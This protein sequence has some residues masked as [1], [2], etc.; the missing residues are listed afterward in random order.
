M[1]R[2]KTAIMAVAIVILILLGFLSGCDFARERI[3]PTI[4]R[5][6]AP[7]TVQIYFYDTPQQV[8]KKYR[9][10]HGIA[11]ESPIQLRDGFAIWPEWRNPVTG[12]AVELSDSFECEVHTARPMHVDDTATLILGHEILHCVYGLY[13]R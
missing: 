1:I 2:I 3:T 7:F 13:H 4:D 6:G 12:A 8:T 11:P 10:I 9:Q 5:E